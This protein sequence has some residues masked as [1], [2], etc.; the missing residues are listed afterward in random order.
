MKLRRIALTAGVALLAMGNIALADT[1]TGSGTGHG[2]DVPVT[3]VYED[4]Q[5]TDIQVGDNSETDGIG[6]KLANHIKGVHHITYMLRHLV[7]LSIKHK[8]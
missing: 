5:I 6:T 7:T 1:F 3:V 4:G 2:G 8:T